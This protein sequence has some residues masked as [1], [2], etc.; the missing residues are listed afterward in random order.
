MGESSPRIER[1]MCQNG[2]A[3]E[4]GDPRLI[5]QDLSVALEQFFRNWMCSSIVCIEI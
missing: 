5:P 1:G 4:W 2:K 3:N